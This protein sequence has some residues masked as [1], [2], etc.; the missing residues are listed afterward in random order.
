M[1]F[2]HHRTN[3]VITLNEYISLSDII[4]NSSILIAC[5]GHLK[6][7]HICSILVI[8]LTICY[9]DLVCI[10]CCTGTKRTPISS[11]H[12]SLIVV[13]CPVFF[14]NSLLF[15]NA[16]QRSLLS[17]FT[18]PSL[19]YVSKLSGHLFGLSCFAVNDRSL[20]LRVHQLCC[21][22]IC[23]CTKWDHDYFKSYLTIWSI[24]MCM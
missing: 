12:K 4:P 24:Y 19:W 20:A 5:L 10:P 9:N 3:L 23:Y 22:Y 14:F 11:Q 21:F 15:P 18:T 2:T 17:T 1:R 13:T 7:I 6:N 8:N 16:G